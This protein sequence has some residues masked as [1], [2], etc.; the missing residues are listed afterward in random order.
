MLRFILCAGVALLFSNNLAQA[1]PT[2]KPKPVTGVIK[3][4]DPGAGTITVTVKKKSDTT[5][6]DFTVADA[7]KITIKD[8]D[9][10]TKDLTGKDGLKDPAV[11]VGAT[12]KVTSAADGS[13]TEVVVN[14]KK[15]A[16]KKA[17]SGT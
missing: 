3:A 5:D 9:G 8:K 17:P 10:T 16:K 13:V 11:I 7:T 6:K 12:V 14:Y 1:A 2:T 15:P 4:V